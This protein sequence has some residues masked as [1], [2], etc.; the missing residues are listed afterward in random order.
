[1]FGK[2]I[3]VSQA[4]QIVR[5]HVVRSINLGPIYMRRKLNMKQLD[6]LADSVSKLDRLHYN[7]LLAVYIEFLVS[8]D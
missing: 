7:T 4:P 3:G 6:N 8:I 1:M 5:Q 2:I